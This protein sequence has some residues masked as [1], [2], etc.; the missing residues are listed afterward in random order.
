[1][2]TSKAAAK[3][4]LAGLNAQFDTVVRKMMVTPAS[5]PEAPSLNAELDALRLQLREANDKLSDPF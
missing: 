1:M 5:S 2:T 3:A 4:H